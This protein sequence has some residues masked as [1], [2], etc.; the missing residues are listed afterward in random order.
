MPAQPKLLH[1][2]TSFTKHVNQR[3]LTHAT[4]K[5]STSAELKL[6]SS[7]DTQTTKDHLSFQSTSNKLNKTTE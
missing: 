2:Q 4:K 1:L 6:Q 7:C 3:Q 5:E